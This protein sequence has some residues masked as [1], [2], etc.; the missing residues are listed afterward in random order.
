[1]PVFILYL[2]FITNTVILFL[3]ETSKCVVVFAILYSFC[4]I[5]FFSEFKSEN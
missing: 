2:T 5:R 1:M 4:Y 3:R